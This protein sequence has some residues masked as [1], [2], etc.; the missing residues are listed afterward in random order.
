MKKDLGLNSNNNQL[1]KADMVS[2]VTPLYNGAKFIAE[3]IESVQAQTYS[4]WEMII[5]DDCSTDN[6]HGKRIVEKYQRTDNRIKLIALNQNLGSSGARN[7]GIQ[8]SAHRYLAFLDADDLWSP[9]F[10][11]KQL[12]FMHRQSA[13][14]A[15]SSYR[16]VDEETGNELLS[17]FIVPTKV[18]Y[19]AILS[20]L[21]IFPSAAIIDQAKLGKRYFNE[22]MG[23]LRDD[24][25]FWLSLLRND[26][27]YA[28]GNQDILCSYRMRKDSVTGNKRKVIIPHWRVLRQVEKLSLMKCIYYMSRWAWIS[29]WKYNQLGRFSKV[30][31]HAKL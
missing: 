8:A 16:R 29:F 30:V 9:F 22:E 19:T 11:E 7:A 12:R 13:L 18:D 21:P 2:I 15:F 27:D 24:Y 17:P 5:V 20:S 26:V 3:T 25:V 31:Q 28:Y 4:K 1:L 6:G 14:I 23:S 10:L